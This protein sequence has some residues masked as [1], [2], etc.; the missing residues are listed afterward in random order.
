MK[1]KIQIG[2]LIVAWLLVVCVAIQVFLAGLNVFLSPVWWGMHIQFGHWIGYVLIA[3]LILVFAGQLPRSLRWLTVLTF[4]LY[5]LQYNFRNLAGLVGVPAL[6]ALHPV[7][8]LLI[9]W[10]AVTLGRSSWQFTR[11]FAK[12]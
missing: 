12:I 3:L 11:A 4:V 1:Y 6:A 9:F 10:C 5:V 8:A 7:N 2:Y